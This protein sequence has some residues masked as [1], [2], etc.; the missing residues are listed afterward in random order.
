MSLVDSEA[1][2][3]QRC[4]EVNA[5]T[6]HTALRD[7][8]VTTFAS[9]AYACGTPQDRPTQTELDAFSTRILGAAPR[10][11]DVSLLKRLIFESCTFVIAQLRQNVQGDASETPKKLPLAEKAARAA[12]Q[13]RRLAGVHIERDSVPSYALVDLCFHMIEVGVTWISPGRCTSRESEI[14]LSTRDQTKVFKLED[15]SLKVGNEGPDDVACFDSPIRLQW[16]LQR[17]GLA[18]DQARLMSWQQHERWVHC[19]LH[20]LTRECPS[21]FHK[22]D[23]NRIVQADREAWLILASEVPSLKVTA[24]GEFPLGVALEALR[25]DPRITMYLMP[26]WGRQPDVKIPLDVPSPPKDGEGLSRSAKRRRRLK[27]AAARNA[28]PPG[29]STSTPKGARAMPAEL[30][31]T[32]QKTE[33][34]KLICWDHNCGGCKLKTDGDPPACQHGVHVCAFCRRAGHSFRNCRARNWKGTGKGKTKEIT[35]QNDD[36]LGYTFS[37]VPVT[38]QDLSSAESLAAQCLN[39]G[40]A[41]FAQLRELSARLPADSVGAPSGQP[42]APADPKSFT[43]G[44]YVHHDKNGLRSNCFAF[45]FSTQLLAR[46]LSAEFPDACFSSVGLFFNLKAP[47]HSD[48]NND[49]RHAN[50]LL[51]A[52][53][54][55]D[56]QVWVEGRGKHPC[57]DLSA[58]RLGYLLDVA[59][60]PQ[61]LPSERL[62]STCPWTGDRLLVVGFCVR[63]TQR[64]C[65]RDCHWLRDSGFP[66]PGPPQ[67]HAAAPRQVTSTTSSP[68]LSTSATPPPQASASIAKR[69]R[70]AYRPALPVHSTATSS[71]SMTPTTPD[72]QHADVLAEKI[73]PNNLA[74]LVIEIFAGTARLS[75]VAGRMGFRTLAVDRSSQRTNFSIQRLDLTLDADLQTLLDIINLEA[76]NIAWIHLAPPCGTAS[77]ARSRPLHKAEHY[78]CPVPQPLRS[79]TEPQ[80]LSTLTGADRDR[81][82]AANKLYR[83]VG[84]IVDLALQLGLFATVENPLNSLAWL[85]DGLDHLCRR[86]DGYQ[87]IFDACMHGGDRDK[88]TLFWCSDPRFQSLALRCSRDHKHASWKPRFVDGHWQFPTAAEAAYPWLLCERMLYILAEGFPALASTSQQP[89]ACEQV[90]LQRQ[91]KYARPLVSCYQSH[92]CWAVPVRS[93]DAAAPLLKCYPKGARVTQRKLVQW[94]A[95]RVCAASKYPGFDRHSSAEL[96]GGT[97]KIYQPDTSDFSLLASEDKNDV[98]EV[99]GMVCDDNPCA[100]QA[101]ILTIGIPREPE[102]FV[103]A[104]V[105]AGHPRNAILVNRQGPAKEIAANVVMPAEERKKRAD[106]ARDAWKKISK[107]SAETNDALMKQKPAYLAKALAGKNVIAWQRILERNGFPDQMLWA[108]LRD[109]FRLTGWMRETGIFKPRVKAPE[110][111]LESLLAQSSYRSPMTMSRITNT[112]PDETS[113]KAWAETQE[114]E[115][116]GWIFE[117]TAPDFSNIVLAHR[118]GLEQK[119]KVRVIDN[120]KDCGLNM[121]CGLPE[122]FTLHGVDVLAAV[123]LELLN[124]PRDRLFKLVGKTIDLVSAYKFYPVHP[125]DRQH[126]RIGVFDTDSKRARIYGTNVLPFGATGSVAGFL[127]VSAAVWHTGVRDMGLGWCA[128]FDDF[129]LLS[130]DGMEEQIEEFADE[131]FEALGIQYAKEGKKATKF[132]A[133]FNAL[134]LAFDLSGFESGVISI[135]HTSDRKKELNDVLANILQTGRLSPKE[136]EVLRGRMHWYSSYLFGRAPCEAMHQLS[137]R[138][139]GIDG[140]SELSADL[141]WAVRTL[142]QHVSTSRPL[143]LRQTSGRELFIFTDGSYKPGAGVVAGIGGII[144]DASG[145]PLAFFSSEIPKSD[146]ELLEAES[147]HPIYEVELYA[148]LVAFMLWAEVL[149]DTF[150]TFYLDNE[151]AQSALIAGRSGTR[152][153][154][155]LLQQ[156]LSLEHDNMARPWFGRVPTH[157]NPADPPSRQ[158]VDHLIR[159]GARQD[160]VD[161]GCLL[162][163]RPPDTG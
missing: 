129:P 109:G 50:L 105:Q 108:D 118:F 36:G 103:K 115:R 2:F 145:V 112:K 96:L 25:T 84:C 95:V 34:G 98:Y 75:T 134:G 107:E 47:L 28:T 135:T 51:P 152:N 19:L 42:V 102:D 81:V 94:G 35:G 43:S 149:R 90:A 67:D 49:H 69:R 32:H 158:I 99:V 153:G 44:A 121:A 65:E 22:P 77:A 4:Q 10:L 130:C 23:M 85:C 143:E 38:A 55:S 59:S 127:R 45:P 113:R 11:G 37:P 101:E 16:C 40:F 52:S 92:D 104:A 138:A 142:L 7:N 82:L 159:Q 6:I 156:V 148:V 131:V 150:S 111:S 89:R 66:L 78:S 70:V 133:V 63:D 154:R 48:R 83:A 144:Y 64:L 120:G 46:I 12:D 26:T 9:L 116:K 163:E 132:D 71:R 123:F 162:L 60:G 73:F 157:S 160:D 147:E 62:H 137:L 33:D 155:R 125:L 86:E 141:D 14:Q 140:S 58:K 76:D 79:V 80:G 74:P 126:L 97:A 15:N 88:T 53:H 87:L 114:E 139:R 5:G 57:P 106:E 124:M 31:G 72:D 161:L 54:F 100:T 20:A 24:A 56:G 128:Y 1:A 13:K 21:G 39:L 91:P 3:T 93:A 8:G 41:S 119:N 29:K 117:D 110:S 30:K 151:A 17:R 146:L 61:Q 18:L 122:K 136:A 27:A 68:S